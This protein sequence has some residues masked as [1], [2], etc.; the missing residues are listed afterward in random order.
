LLL[1][2]GRNAKSERYY[3][4]RSR[5]YKQGYAGNGSVEDSIG[6]V[7]DYMTEPAVNFDEDERL[8]DIWRCLLDVTFRRVPVTSKGKVVGIVSRP[9]VLKFVIEDM[10]QGSLNFP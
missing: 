10:G 4:A 1:A 5:E 9:D 7:E 6:E 8:Y 2:G 3:D